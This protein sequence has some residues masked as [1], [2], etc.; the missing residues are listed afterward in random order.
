MF[1]AYKVST[2]AVAL[3]ATQP[4]RGGEPLKIGNGDGKRA[5]LAL[6]NGKLSGALQLKVLAGKAT[7]FAIYPSNNGTPI[8]VA[9][10]STGALTMSGT[11]SAAWARNP[12]LTLKPHPTDTLNA[13]SSSNPSSTPTPEPTSTTS[14]SA[15]SPTNPKPSPSAVP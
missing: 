1:V 3:P 13:T 5:A 14:T 2:S 15:G 4:T 7:T 10:S 8:L 12:S 11:L 9:V 6:A